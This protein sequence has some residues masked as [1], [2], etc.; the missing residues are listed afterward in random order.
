M[1]AH[2]RVTLHQLAMIRNSSRPLARRFVRDNVVYMKEKQKK[3]NGDAR[4]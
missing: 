4:D 3:G 2:S 1:K